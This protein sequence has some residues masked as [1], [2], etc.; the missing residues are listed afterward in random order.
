VH[1]NL[2]PIDEAPMTSFRNGTHAALLAVLISQR[3]ALKLTL[4]A[5]AGRMP[6]YLGWDTTLVKVEK[7]RRNVSFVEARELAR[8]LGT[9]LAG[10]ELAVEAL[11]N[12]NDQATGGKSRRRQS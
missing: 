7:G 9:N 12:A 10:L 2:V 1:R 5:V 4:R 3:K 8:I 11:E 6:K